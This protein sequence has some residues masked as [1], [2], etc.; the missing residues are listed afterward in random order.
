[1]NDQFAGGMFDYQTFY[2]EVAGILL[3]KYCRIAEIGAGDGASIIYLAKCLHKEATIFS[4]DNL[5]YGGQAQA[6]NI[7]DNIEKSGVS[8]NMIIGESVESAALFADDSF[9][10]VFIDSSHKYR[11]TKAEIKCWL[12]KIKPGGILAGHD[13]FGEPAVKHAVDEMIEKEKLETRPTGKGCG[14]WMT[15]KVGSS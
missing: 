6:D 13:Y 15:R 9:D 12:K 2:R 14:V 3:S 1:M 8:V 5:E 7:R 10:F 11:E 4:I